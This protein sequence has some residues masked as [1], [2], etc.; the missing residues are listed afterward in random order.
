MDVQALDGPLTMDT[1]TG[2]DV[3]HAL[4]RAASA[5]MPAPGYL[6]LTHRC[7][8]EWRHGTHECVRHINEEVR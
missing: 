2:I 3:A 8:Q 4:M 7:R 5:L 6:Q 1:V